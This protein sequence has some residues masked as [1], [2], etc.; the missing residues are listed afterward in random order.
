MQLPS[1]RWRL[2]IRQK[3]LQA[4]ELFDTEEAAREK[5]ARLLAARNQDPGKM[6]LAQVWQL[7]LDSEMFEAKAEKTQSTELGRIKPVLEKF[8]NYSLEDLASNVKLVKEYKRERQKTISPRT[9]KKM[10]NTSVRLEMAAYSA[11]IEFAVEEDLLDVNFVNQV[12]R[13][14]PAVRKRRVFQEEQG[15]LAIFARNSDPAVAQAARFQLLIR[16]LGCRPGELRDLLV[17]DVA[18]LRREV[19]FWD[20]K[21]GTDRRAHT[22]AEALTMLQLQLDSV[23]EGSPYLFPTWSKYKKA[24]VPYVYA[25][26]VKRLRELNVVLPDY[27]AHAGRRE[28][29]SR[30]IEGNVPHMTIKKQTGHKSTQ[31]LEIYDRGLS[32]APTIRAELDRLAADVKDE[33]LMG[34]LRALGLT[35]EQ[36][37]RLAILQGKNMD[38]GTDWVNV[39]NADGSWN[40]PF[41]KE[42][43]SA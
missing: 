21:N 34:A 42:P 29:V 15:K 35:P 1:G 19:T 6:T 43:G 32:T 17:R 36:E 2:Q 39:Q 20:T 10:S 22:T 12:K 31:A 4:D 24:W 23:P 25:N 18:M 38:G 11:V 13:P 33:G 9:K 16:H 30:A 3:K 41:Q 27:H 26:G 37:R 40:S 14:A 8:G 7:Y 28:F 5:E